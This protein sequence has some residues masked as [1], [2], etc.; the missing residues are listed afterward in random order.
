M[1]KICFVASTGGHWEEIR[2]LGEVAEGNDCFYVTE[3][4]GQVEETDLSPLYLFPKINR[5]EKGFLSHFI[6][7]AA[8]SRKIIKKEQ[9]DVVISTGALLSFPF[10]LWA[11]LMGKKVIY[12]ESFARV[13]SPSL[14]GKLVYKFA[15]LFIVQWES[16]LEFYPNAVYTG[17]IF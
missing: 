4:G 12:I 15:D 8:E 10:C 7:L 17:G 9:P 5:K 1:K 14:T 13:H 6:K 2:C 3:E 16:M 11:K